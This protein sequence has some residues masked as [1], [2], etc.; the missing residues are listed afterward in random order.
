MVQVQLSWRRKTSLKSRLY[1]QNVPE[2]SA[3]HSQQSAPPVLETCTNNPASFRNFA[4][5]WMKLSCIAFATFETA[6][7]QRLWIISSETVV[8]LSEPATFWTRSAGKLGWTGFNPIPF[9]LSKED[10]ICASLWLISLKK[11]YIIICAL[12]MFGV[13][14]SFP[15]KDKH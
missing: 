11:S 14:F 12:S 13:G 10:C 1:P 7:R 6:F 3:H 2:T 8:S 15:H 5:S 4:F 9:L